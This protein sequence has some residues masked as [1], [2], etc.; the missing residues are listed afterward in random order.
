[1]KIYAL[2]VDP[3]IQESP[4]FLDE[5]FFPENINVFGNRYF[6]A[7]CMDVFA[8]VREVLYSGDLLDEWD[9]LNSGGEPPRRFLPLNSGEKIP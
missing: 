6:N 1:M 7:H 3:E 2:Q 8:R 5:E 9:K 4:L